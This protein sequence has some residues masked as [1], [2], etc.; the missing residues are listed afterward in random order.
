M[1]FVSCALPEEY[2]SNMA[3]VKTIEGGV[4]QK[5]LAGVA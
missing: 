4:L 3:C 5:V 1:V 2:G